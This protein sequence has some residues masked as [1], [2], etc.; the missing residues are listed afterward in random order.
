MLHSESKKHLR[1]IDVYQQC[2]GINDGRDER[3][4]HHGGVEAYALRENRQRTA[5]R[6]C[7]DDGHRE[8]DAYCKC[9]ERRYS[10]NN[11]HLAEVEHGK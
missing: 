4:R 6:F 11:E 9:N 10:V 7:D 8:R 3:T 1:N 2:H 5:D